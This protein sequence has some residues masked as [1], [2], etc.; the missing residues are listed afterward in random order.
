MH[1]AFVG[2]SL[3]LVVAGCIVDRSPLSGGPE[4]DGGEPPPDVAVLED[5]PA[6]VDSPSIVDTCTEGAMRCVEEQR[7]R[8]EGGAWRE[9][10]CTLGCVTD[11]VGARCLGLVPSNVGG[12]PLVDGAGAPSMLSGALDTSA[13]PGGEVVAQGAGE[14]ELCVLRYGGPLAVGALS[15]TGA[16]ALVLL[17][18]GGVDVVGEVR[19]VGSLGAAGPG[20]GAGATDGTTATGAG[21]GGDGVEGGGLEDGGGGGGGSCGAGAR[22]GDSADDGLRGAPGAA[23]PPEYLLEP[24]RGGGGGGRGATRGTGGGGGGALQISAGGAILLD[25]RVVVGGGPGGGGPGPGNSAAGAGGGGGGGLLLESA[26]GVRYGAAALVIASGGGGGGGGSVGTTGENGQPGE[27]EIPA[28]GGDTGSY[29]AA[30]GAGGGGP[31]TP[32]VEGA[33]IDY[34]S[35][36]GGGGGGQ[37]CVIVRAPDAAAPPGTGIFRFAAPRVE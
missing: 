10:P 24:L 31:S 13:C 35:N 15:V 12:A 21:A 7:E 26:A 2:A 17:A 22:G 30:G 33:T 8:C 37:G 27:V 3:S 34:V 16:R 14:P 19:L 23:Y 5:A 1:R 32:P 9:A 29:G 6:P 28:G 25:A 11:G 20:G 4:R 36:G 18:A